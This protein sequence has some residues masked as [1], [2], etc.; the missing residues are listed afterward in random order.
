[1]WNLVRATIGPTLKAS[2]TYPSVNSATPP[3]PVISIEAPKIL[4][5]V[6]PTTSKIL[7]AMRLSDAFVSTSA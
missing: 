4:L 7:R 1:M 5:P 3:N 6:R 2:Y